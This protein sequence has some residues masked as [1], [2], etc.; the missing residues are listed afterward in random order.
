VKAEPVAT[1]VFEASN[2]PGVVPSKLPAS[3]SL[4]SY[5]SVSC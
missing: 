2:Q 4:P 3:W 5:V 1:G